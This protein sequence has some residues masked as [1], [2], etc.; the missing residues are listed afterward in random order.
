VPVAVDYDGNGTADLA[1]YRHGTWYLRSIATLDW[2][3]AT[4]VPAVRP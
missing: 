3:T 1:V 2:G 4:D